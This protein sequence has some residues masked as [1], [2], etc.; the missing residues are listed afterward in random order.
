MQSYL[1]VT[2]IYKIGVVAE[3]SARRQCRIS[4]QLY[5]IGV[6][7]SDAILSSPTMARSRP[8]AGG[9]GWSPRPTIAVNRTS[10]LEGR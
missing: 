7:E 3:T 6:A 10:T 1:P 2:Q 4:D 8:R 5:K 9:V